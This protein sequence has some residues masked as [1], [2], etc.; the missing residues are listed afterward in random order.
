MP[1]CQLQQPKCLLWLL[2]L[3]PFPP[4][5]PAPCPGD[6]WPNLSEVTTMQPDTTTG[7]LFPRSHLVVSCALCGAKD[8]VRA[9]NISSM[10]KSILE[11]WKTLR[12]NRSEIWIW[13]TILHVIRTQFVLTS[14]MNPIFFTLNCFLEYPYQKYMLRNVFLITSR[15]LFLYNLSRK[16][17]YSE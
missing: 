11:N 1:S 16:M 6:I 7:A 13:K 5:K 17:L 3:C 4:H 9:Q 15:R 8:I 14:Q 10:N 2:S 12:N